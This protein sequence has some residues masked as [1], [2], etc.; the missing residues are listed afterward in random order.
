MI[1]HAVFVC[2][3]I[4]CGIVLAQGMPRHASYYYSR[5]PIIVPDGGTTPLVQP[6]L[7]FAPTQA[8][9]GFFRPYEGLLYAADPYAV[10][11][12]GGNLVGQWEVYT[13]DGG[14][15]WDAG[16][17]AYTHLAAVSFQSWPRC[18]NGPD[19]S[20][21]TRLLLE[22]DAG[23]VSAASRATA[24]N[25][26]TACWAGYLDVPPA[27][28]DVVLYG[29][30]TGTAAADYSWALE[31]RT[32]GAV[33][34][35]ASNGTTI[36]N[37]PDRVPT[38]AAEN[39]LC[40]HW[41]PSSLDTC[42][43]GA[44]GTATANPA[45]LN[46][47]NAA[48]T[49]NGVNGVPNNVAMSVRTSFAFKTEATMNTEAL[50]AAWFASKPYG[51]LMDGGHLEFTTSLTAAQSCDSF[52]GGTVEILSS[53]VGQP[54]VAG[55]KVYTL[56]SSSNELP[57]SLEFDN[58]AWTKGKTSTA[59]VPTVTANAGVGFNGGRTADRVIFDRCET[60]GETSHIIYQ[61]PT[62]LGVARSY[63][64]WMKSYDGGTQTVTACAGSWDITT[65]CTNY[66]VGANW[67]RVSEYDRGANTEEAPES[68]GLWGCFNGASYVGATANANLADVLLWGAHGEE[69]HTTNFSPSQI[70][71]TT[72]TASSG[73]PT[74]TATATTDIPAQSAT[75]AARLSTGLADHTEVGDVTFVWLKDQANKGHI[76]AVDN[77]ASSTLRCRIN[78]DNTSTDGT[79]SYS[80]GTDGGVSG[81][82]FES[83][84]T[85]AC[86][87][88][89]CGSWSPIDGGI[90]GLASTIFLGTGD[91]NQNYPRGYGIG[92]VCIDFGVDAGRCGI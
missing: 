30:T 24:N 76:M 27:T 47:V 57:R 32:N 18:P 68:Y 16:A 38:P 86:A 44:C 9:S 73:L 49:I 71:T 92:D 29:Q 3:L 15:A 58:A 40:C 12:D 75:V 21:I 4:V 25:A 6:Y 91:I 36:Y 14:H 31:Y 83:G 79:V 33:R 2:A 50:E 48:A 61:Q 88:G 62:G 41:A 55:G 82:A 23:A 43:N 64:I 70:I 22:Q 42:A 60:S 87:G 54:C 85:L 59:A 78:P 1:R 34:C 8:D 53:G 35:R 26:L 37:G 77:T 45:T 52:D 67:T 7:R 80:R 74:M 5:S 72:G 66:S 13:P 46:E 19:C 39:L 84:R 28:G 20:L 11:L 56:P 65:R 51:I 69:G 63:A 10:L 90:Q 81:C 17:V 89:T